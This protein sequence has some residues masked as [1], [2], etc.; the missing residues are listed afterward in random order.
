[1]GSSFP[2]R[3]VCW[4]VAINIQKDLCCLCGWMGPQPLRLA[5]AAV[6]EQKQEEP[7]TQAPVGRT[8][9][10]GNQLENQCFPLEMDDGGRGQGGG[11]AGSSL[12][13]GDTLVPSG[14]AGLLGKAAGM[15]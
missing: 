1:M 5:L 3:G 9:G 8:A 10:L 15:A 7:V 12:A 14:R 4:F 11:D 6:L 13:T 2:V